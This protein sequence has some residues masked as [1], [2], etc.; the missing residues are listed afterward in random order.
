MI[1]RKWA[2]QVLHT[3]PGALATWKTTQACHS[4]SKLKWHINYTKLFK[5]EPLLHGSALRGALDA[6]KLEARQGLSAFHWFHQ[7]FQGLISSHTAC[8]SAY[9]STHWTAAHWE[10]AHVANWSPRLTSFCRRV[11]RVRG[12]SFWVLWGKKHIYYTVLEASFKDKRHAGG[13]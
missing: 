8:A 1:V 5:L 10:R 4:R 13:V 3:L 6:T 7:T 12:W 2:W 9:S 11:N